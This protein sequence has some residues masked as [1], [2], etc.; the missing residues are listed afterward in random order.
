MSGELLSASGEAAWQGLRQHIEWTQG[1]WIGWVFT[2]HAPSMHELHQRVAGQLHVVGRSAVFRQ[3]REPGE[4]V[5][6]LAWLL[7][8]ADGC[9][10]CVTIA[11]VRQE[12]AWQEAWDQF[13]LRLNERREL[14]RQQ[15]RGGLLLCAPTKFKARSREAAPDLWSIRSLALDV[16]P[17]VGI[18]Q[19]PMIGLRDDVRDDMPGNLEA[20][21]LALQAVG[22]AQRAGQADAETI[23][24]IR[25]A[26]ALFSVGRRDEGREQAV[27]AVQ[28]APTAALRAR[29]LVLLADLESK[30]EDHVAAERHYRA[31]IAADAVASGPKAH[32]AL[33][34]LLSMRGAL[35]D[36]HSVATVALTQSRERRAH[37]GD[38]VE[39]L[40]DE[41][42]SLDRLGAVLNA[43]GDWS[44][45]GAAYEEAL[46][47]SRRIREQDGDTIA[48]LRSLSVSLY[49]V[50]DA[51]LD[52][53]DLSGARAAHEES[54]ELR[55]RLRELTG[56]S[57]AR[58]VRDVSLGLKG[59]GDVLKAQGDWKGAEAAFREALG[60]IRRVREISGDTASTLSGE[61]LSVSRV[62]EALRAQGD[63]AGA[64]T[65]FEEA[66]AL[67][68]RV[69]EM[70][71]ETATVLRHVSV[72]L[73]RFGTVLRAQGDW[74]GAGAAYGEGLALSR[75]VRDM[76]GD[77]VQAVDDLALDLR[78]CAKVHR[79]QGEITDARS[80]LQDAVE[81][82]RGVRARG[83]MSQRISK[84]L[85]GAL[86]DLADVLRDEAAALRADDPLD[87]L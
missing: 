67:S 43:Q 20:V 1:F 83:N 34:E 36:A 54:L 27:H 63:L 58:S 29:A 28:V 50:G 33:S 82:L 37:D 81:M 31:A 26:D 17:V 8:G 38:T 52:R 30:L 70:V 15:I 85:A 80:K 55:R 9:D 2:D 57:T 16:A 60:L 71:G 75:R 47:L 68:R 44:G 53:G 84:A 65:A 42:L 77:T 79:H 45:A 64:R 22:A 12:E 35:D 11:V 78:H 66:L 6:V 19:E 23:A 51:L 39:A 62:G 48:A 24:R 13:L 61:A 4:L 69:R 72:R 25:A 32:R 74:S 86:E 41:R 59:V 56:D 5:E 21:T 73:E 14:L 3:L 76:V 10:G 46:R 40:Q 87:G 49:R 7:A 18:R